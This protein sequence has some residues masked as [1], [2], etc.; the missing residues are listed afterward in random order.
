MILPQINT[1]I[2]DEIWVDYILFH[3]HFAVWMKK[4]EKQDVES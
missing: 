1:R 3:C 4:Q 2:C